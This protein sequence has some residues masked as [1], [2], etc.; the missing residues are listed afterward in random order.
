VC[1]REDYSQAFTN[2]EVEELGGLMEEFFKEMKE[3]H[4]M[5][6]AY[7]R[8]E[9]VEGTQRQGLAE[10]EVVDEGVPGG[11]YHE[12]LIPP[13]FHGWF[14]AVAIGRVPGIYVSWRDAGGQTNGF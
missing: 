13:D 12:D 10:R 11:G 4:K 9:V 3:E 1:G 14:Y 7:R 2:A 5:L 8:E 6:S